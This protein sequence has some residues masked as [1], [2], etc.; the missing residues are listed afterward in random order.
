M[1]MSGRLEE[2]KRWVRTGAARRLGLWL[3]LSL[4][5]SV[6][7][8]G[9]F[10]TTLPAM[11]SPNWVFRFHAAPWGVLA[12]CAIFLWLKRK[13]LNLNGKAK[14]GGAKS[15]FRFHAL[16]FM[17][18]AGLVTAAILMPAT[19]DFLVFRVLVAGLGVFVVLFGQSA[20]IPAVLLAIYGFAVAFPLALERFGEDAY[21][22]TS[23]TPLAAVINALGH[24]LQSQGQWVSFASAG[25]EPISAAVTVACAGSATMGV[26]IALFVLMM[27]DRPLPRKKAVALFLFGAAGTWLQSLLRLVIIILAGY[28]LGN[29]AMWTAH[30]W[31]VYI[32]FPLWYLLFVYIYFRQFKAEAEPKAGFGYEAAGG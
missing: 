15:N 17:A 24:P 32:L 25:G 10:W 20:R 6:I 3:V 9:D 19:Q 4:F 11:L 7:F 13:Q 14:Y 22:R 29:D 5:L 31:T 16:N 8:F 28:H 27:L 21:S 26:F 18:G 2:L 12:L 30:Y 23:I 1:K